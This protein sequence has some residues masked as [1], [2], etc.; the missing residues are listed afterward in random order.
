[1]A[2]ATT[3][4]VKVKEIMTK[5]VVTIEASQSAME[6]TKLLSNTKR[7]GRG[8]GSLVVVDRGEVIGIITE[9]DLVERVLA[10][11]LNPEKTRVEE[12]MT[13]HVIFCTPEMSIRD[14]AALLVKHGFRHL[15]VIEDNKLVGIVAT[16]DII[17]HAWWIPIT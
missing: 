9:R 15:P 3:L 8:I 16:Y 7:W 17:L 10:K 14:A 4:P 6:A 12:F 1:M 11:G 2:E 5:D 13:K